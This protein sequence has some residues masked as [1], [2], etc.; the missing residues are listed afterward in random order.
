MLIIFACLCPCMHACMYVR[1]C[2]FN[3]SVRVCTL[4]H[5]LT[6]IK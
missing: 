1:P 6:A 3:V 5:A 2:D 4:L